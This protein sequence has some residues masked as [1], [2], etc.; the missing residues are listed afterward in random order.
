MTQR[1]EVQTKFIYGWENV[2]R[3]EDGK[4][5]YFNTREQAIKELRKNVDDW[6]NDPNTTSKYYYSDYRVKST[7]QTDTSHNLQANQ[8]QAQA[9]T[10]ENLQAQAIACP[11]ITNTYPSTLQARKNFW[12]AENETILDE[13]TSELCCRQLP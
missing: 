7:G 3:D 5:I 10:T 2:W 1:Y 6:N 13:G 4:L 11:Q 12:D 8:P 9:M